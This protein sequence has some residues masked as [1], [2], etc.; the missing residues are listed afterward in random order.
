MLD[1]GTIRTSATAATTSTVTIAAPNG[2]KL[3]LA[4]A[5][6]DAL[7]SDLV[8]ALTNLANYIRGA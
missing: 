2:R 5:D 4:C 7:P 3:L 1:N 8:T 6:V